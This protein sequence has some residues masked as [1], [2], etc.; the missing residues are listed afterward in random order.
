MPDYLTI[1]DV[2][3]E[4]GV[5]YKTVYRLVTSGKLPSFRVGRV[6]RIR[7]Q[8][9]DR[10]IEEQIYGK[11]ARAAP[12]EKLT[13][14]V[15]G[16]VIPSIDLVGGFCQH[17]G[18]DEPICATCWGRGVRHCRTHQPSPEDKLS[19]ARADMLT[20]KVDRV[21]TALQARQREKAFIS[22]FEK[23]IM[24]IAA[25]Q[26]PLTGEL[27]KIEAWEPFHET[28]DESAR[29]LQALGVA[30]LERSILAVTPVNERSRFVIKPGDLGRKRPKQ[31]IAIDVQA[32]SDI[33]AMT[34]AGYASQPTPLSELMAHLEEREKEAHK[35]N[36]FYVVALGATAG[37]DEESIRYISASPQG[38]SYQHRL[39]APLLVDLH[40]AQLHYNAL[41]QRLQGF[42][43]LFRLADEA[44]EVLRIRQWIEET[45]AN[46]FR[47]GITLQEVAATLGVQP[48][49][50]LEAFQQLANQPGFRQM[51]DKDAGPMLIVVD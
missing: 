48:P 3:D 37:W 14:S 28:S 41:D 31:G 12:A 5:E 43:D 20:G 15:C 39:L 32:I 47:S 38:T 50:A 40:Q 27:L 21:V 26:H 23:R 35:L 29:L 19:Q 44:E 13:C 49:L 17:P 24:G 30:F 10:Y 45:I 25:L 6:Y 7:R 1:Q 2:A 8:D 34:S 4:M 33:E 36:A 51:T 16:A 11:D 18:C 22:R 42:I 46:D 9:L